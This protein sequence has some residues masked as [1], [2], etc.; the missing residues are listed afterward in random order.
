ME[1]RAECG[2]CHAALT[3]DAAAYHCAND[4]TFCPTCYRRARFECPNCSGELVRRPRRT[5]ARAHRPVP[6]ADPSITIRIAGPGDLDVLS[7]LFDAYRCF[8]EHASDLPASKAF[9]G[10]RIARGESTVFIAEAQGRAVGFVQMYP[11]FSSVSLGRVYVLNDLF[12]APDARQR[13]VGAALLA[14]ARRWSEQQGTRY[15]T[16]STA[17]DNPA[18]RLY[19]ACGWVLD[20]EFLYYELPLLSA[21]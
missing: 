11:M 4:C 1:R 10:E 18:Q 17:V 12:V 21:D 2:R 15:L 19:E 16:L 3:E 20:R 5:A 9:L 6:P 13:G 8:Y 7:L 14:F